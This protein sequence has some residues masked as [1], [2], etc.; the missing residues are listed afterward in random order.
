MDEEIE[1]IEKIVEEIQS[2]KEDRQALIPQ[3]LFGQQGKPVQEQDCF[4]RSYSQK[5]EGKTLKR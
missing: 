1:S 4:N 3:V 2:S 5:Q